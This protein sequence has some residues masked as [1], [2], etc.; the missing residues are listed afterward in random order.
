MFV[1]ESNNH[2]YTNLGHV[3]FHCQMNL[4]DFYVFWISQKTLREGKWMPS[5]V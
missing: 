2:E 3:R 4:K 5:K 1:Y